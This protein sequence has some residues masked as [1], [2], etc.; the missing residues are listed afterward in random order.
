MQVIDIILGCLLLYGLVRGFWNGFFIEIASLFSLLLGIFIAIKFSSFAQSLLSSHVSWS[1]KTI[2]ITAFALTF[3]AVVIGLSVLAKFLTTISKFAGL[4]I[5]NKIAGAFFGL[6]KTI[7]LMSVA[8]HFFQKMNSKASFV[9]KEQLVKSILY[10]PTLEVS[11][12]IYPTLESWFE[13][14]YPSKEER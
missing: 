8:L 7:L 11:G 6:L 3:I 5:F 10:Y 13:E 14:F 12:K 1:P 2:Q 4:G 9:S